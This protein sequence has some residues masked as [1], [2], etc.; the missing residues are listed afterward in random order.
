MAAVTPGGPTG[1]HMAS[2]NNKVAGF[3]AATWRA[4]KQLVC[5]LSCSALWALGGLSKQPLGV[6]RHLAD[7]H[8]GQ[9]WTL[10]EDHKPS[11]HSWLTKRTEL[12]IRVRTGETS[13][14]IPIR[15][16]RWKGCSTSLPKG[17]RRRPVEVA[18]VQNI[19]R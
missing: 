11:F 16:H 3:H 6:C 13:N 18:S 5:G 7:R 14:Y 4:P 8:W 10:T 2:Q 1:G 12:E 19:Y 17:G 9:R 15:P